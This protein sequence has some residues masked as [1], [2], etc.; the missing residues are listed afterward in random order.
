LQNY[1]NV[2]EKMKNSR[3][4][5]VIRL[6]KEQLGYEQVLNNRAE[7]FGFRIE[8]LMDMIRT[9]EQIAEPFTTMEA[10][11]KRLK[12]LDELTQKAKKTKDPNAVT[13]STF[14]SAKGLEFDHVYMIDCHNGTIPSDEDQRDNEKIE[15][16]RRLFY[17]G[18]TRARKHLELLTYAEKDGKE[19]VE[20]R[21]ISEVRGILLKNANNS[22]LKRAIRARKSEY[23]PQSERNESRNRDSP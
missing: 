23:H 14:H 9:L 4:K 11:A 13:L 19:K 15:E 5:S 10:F 20:S 22:N 2:Y 12:E 18:M 3:P 7:K 6:I 17:V 21:F 1:A 8:V 16:A